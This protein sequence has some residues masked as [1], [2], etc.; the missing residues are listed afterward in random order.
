[1]SRKAMSL[2]AKIRNLA[3]KKHM[4]AQ[5][6]LQNYMFERF[7]E[8]LSK[9]D[10]NDKFILKGGMLIAA[11]VGIDNRATMD[12]DA[13]IKNYPI[14]SDSLTKAINEICCVE[15]NDDVVF[16]FMGIDSIRDED[17]YGG[18]RVSIQA[19]YDTIITPM[20][21]DITTGDAITPKEVL[22][23][24]KMIFEEGTIGVWAYNIETVLAEKVETILRRG[25]LNTRPRDFYDVYILTKTQ[26]FDDSVFMEALRKTTEHR[27]TTHIF[28]DI[29]KRIEDLQ[30]SDSL[31]SRW[32]KYTKDYR[33]A[34]DISYDDVINALRM[35][36]EF[37]SR[38]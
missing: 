26:N 6:V 13:T 16:S 22:Y 36:I 29:E 15:V 30:K 4:S 34:E 20:Q 37:I 9:S 8:R 27:E 24:F 38:A 33:Y 11:L 25:E 21:I 14:N 10:Y 3:K 12:M 28:N 35:L 1:M 7:L 18:Y 17:A 5:V 32:M 19:D 2:K 23:L 31:K